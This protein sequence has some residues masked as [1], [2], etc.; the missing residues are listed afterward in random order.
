MLTSH[1]AR[2]MASSLLPRLA[3]V[4]LMVAL[5]GCDMFGNGGGGGGSLAPGL[6]A[7]MDRPGASL[8]RPTAFGVLNQYRATVGAGPLTDDPSL[9]AQAQGL[10]QA[11]A[12]TDKAPPMPAGLVGMRGSAG[13]ANFAETFSGWRN[14]PADAAILGSAKATRG[15]LAAVYDAT[16][17]YGVYWIF[18]L[19]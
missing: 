12:K 2:Y 5:S 1:V 17:T 14:S 8:D 16:A 19:G 4:A 3:A 6:T 10:A 13:Y 18:V 9:D 11:Y 15:G 7:G